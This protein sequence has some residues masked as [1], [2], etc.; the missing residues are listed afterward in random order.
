MT[1]S[2]SPED[3]IQQWL[4]EEAVGSLPD[5]VIDATFERSR[6][7]RQALWSDWRPFSMSRPF[8]AMIAVG[9]TAIVVVIGAAMLFSPS[10]LGLKIELPAA[11]PSVATDPSGDVIDATADLALDLGSSVRADPQP[12]MPSPR[13]L[14]TGF[15]TGPIDVVTTDRTVTGEVRLDSTHELAYSRTG[16]PVNH[17]WGS[18]TGQLDS[19]SCTGSLA[20]SF[21]RDGPVGGT[22]FLRCADGSS[23]GGE[24]TSVAISMAGTSWR[25]TA[26]MVGVYRPV[27]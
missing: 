1:R 23:L 26:H 12:E 20:Y 21:Y 9:A 5:R 15:W 27:D 4:E 10:R 2:R 11:G 7:T 19:A 17:A 13:V 24:L 14:E 16:P 6:G 3:R 18:L 25:L 22:I 8:S